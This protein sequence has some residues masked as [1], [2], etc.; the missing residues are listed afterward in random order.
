MVKSARYLATAL[1]LLAV[2]AAAVVAADANWFVREG[3][4]PISGERRCL[5]ESSTKEV[6]DGQTTTSMRI[7]YTGQAFAIVTDSNVDLSYPGIGIRVDGHEAASM[8]GLLGET[9]VKIES[10]ADALV[11]RFKRGSQAQVALGFWPTWPQTD[12]VVTPF[13]LIGFTRAHGEF[14]QCTAGE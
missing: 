1:A 7:V 3:L 6:D 9:S 14:L 8:D 11:E 2:I 4:D 12:T 13:S 10:D 5:L